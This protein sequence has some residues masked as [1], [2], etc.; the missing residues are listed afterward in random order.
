MNWEMEFMTPS[1][2]YYALNDMIKAQ[3]GKDIDLHIRGIDE[4][5]IIHDSVLI[6]A[7][8]TSF[9]MHLQIAPQDF[10]SSYNWAQAISGPLLT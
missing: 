9:Q 6:E 7:C 1:P 8:N 10:I 3:R 5:S 4:L 2:R